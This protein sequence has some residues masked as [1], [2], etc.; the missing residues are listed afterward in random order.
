MFFLTQ[1]SRLVV[2]LAT[3]L[4]EFFS[5][6]QTIEIISDACHDVIVSTL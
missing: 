2:L 6:K 5:G 3:S 1:S 4:V